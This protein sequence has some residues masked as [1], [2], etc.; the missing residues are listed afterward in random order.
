MSDLA[1]KTIVPMNQETAVLNTLQTALQ[2]GVDADSLEKLLNMQ[3]RV[4]DRQSEQAYAQS[5]VEVQRTMPSIK[6]NKQNDQTRSEYADMEQINKTITPV[7]TQAG[8]CLSFGNADSPH[9]GHVRVTCDVMHSLG[10]SKHYYTDVPLDI[11]GIKGNRNKTQVHGTGSAISYG[12][13]YLIKLIFNLTTGDDDDGNAAGG[14]TRSA[15][16]VDN[17][18]IARVSVWREILP[19]I[20]S[21]KEGIALNELEQAI[22]SWQELSEDEMKAVWNPAPSKGGILTTQER[23]VMKSNEWAE[24]RNNMT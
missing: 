20:L 8:F 24:V 19:S 22:E 2:K 12:Q 17:D 11:E 9:D 13:R 7:Y 18:W 14:D 23:T 5:M 15:L 1:E 10:H 16:E 6:K 3:E 21:I 4:L